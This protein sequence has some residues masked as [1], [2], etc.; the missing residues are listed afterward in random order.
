MHNENVKNV[1][2]IAILKSDDMTNADMKNEEQ[3]PHLHDEA[4]VLD[5]VQHLQNAVFLD[6][7]TKDEY[8]EDH[9]KGAINIDVL[10]DGYEA[11]LEALDSSK[12]YIVYCRSGARSLKATKFLIDHKKGALNVIGGI[13]TVDSF[14][15]DNK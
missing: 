15:V 9:V 1:R 5:A 8:L 3:Y 10:E 6:V 14:L 12:T 7:R 11:K 13:S 4:E 2:K